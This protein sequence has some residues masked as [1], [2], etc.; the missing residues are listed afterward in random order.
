MSTPMSTA[1]SSC[2]WPLLCL[3]PT[4]TAVFSRATENQARHR[5]PLAAKPH[6]SPSADRLALEDVFPALRDCRLE[7]ERREHEAMTAAA[8]SESAWEQ[9]LADKEQ[10]YRLSPRG[11]QEEYFAAVASVSV[12][13]DLGWCVFNSGR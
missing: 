8:A 3:D 9:E 4:F 11:Q 6:S 1:G 13:V 2:K 12:Q 5:E 7:Q 10:R